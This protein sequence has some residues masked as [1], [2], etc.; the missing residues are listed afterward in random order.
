MQEDNTPPGAFVARMAARRPRF[1]A[2]VVTV[3]GLLV[4]F[5]LAYSATELAQSLKPASPS[6]A[7]RQG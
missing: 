3:A 5:A 6:F 1:A 7:A 4:G 2:G